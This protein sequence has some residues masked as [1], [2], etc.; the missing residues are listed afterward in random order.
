MYQPDG[1]AY[2]NIKGLEIIVTAN[3]GDAREYDNFE[4][5]TRIEDGDI[6]LDQSVDP[7]G[8]ERIKI[9][10]TLGDTDG[11]GDYD[12]LYSFGARSFSI[13]SGT[14]E[15]IYDSGNDIGVQTLRLTPER[16]NDNDKRSDDK[17]GEP[18]SVAI[19]QLRNNKWLLFVGLERNDQ[20]LVY[21]ISNPYRPRFLQILSNGGDEVGDLAPEGLLVVSEENSPT[22]KALL[23]VSN[24]D[25]GTVSIYQNG[26]LEL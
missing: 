16:F 13:W 6:I 17:A 19:L 2:A 8:L 22:G 26:D 14:G 18:E 20:V 5:E 23:I 4:E 9:T 10:K 12:E 15:L 24:E 7:T 11:D 1:I 25:S 21:D 3:E